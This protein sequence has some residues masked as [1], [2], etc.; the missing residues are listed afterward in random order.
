MVEVLGK[1]PW[2]L[3]ANGEIL[4]DLHQRLHLI[5]APDGMAPGPGPEGS[6][7]LHL[8]LHPLNVIL[9]P[10][11]PVVIDWT[12]ARRGEAAADVA[13]T[14]ILM[15]AGTIPGNRL[16]AALMGRARGVLVAGFLSGFLS[17]TDRAAVVSALRPVVEWKIRDPHM[18]AAEID[19]MWAVVRKAEASGPT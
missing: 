2:T 11:G 19:G 13:L 6:S 15:S 9:G 12:N 10:S 16:K 14:W 17:A 1:K 4:A 18:S 5:P 7:L 8:D 3:R